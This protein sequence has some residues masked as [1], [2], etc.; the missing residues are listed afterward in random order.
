MN[1]DSDRQCRNNGYR[2]YGETMVRTSLKD[3]LSPL[4]YTVD[5]IEMDIVV[6][7]NLN[8]YVRAS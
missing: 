5:D 4:R 1:G 3:K 8:R 2:Q 7:L 6:F